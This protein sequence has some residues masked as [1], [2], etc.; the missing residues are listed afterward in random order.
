METRVDVHSLFRIVICFDA[1][2]VVSPHAHAHVHAA[3]DSGGGAHTGHA[4]TT[5]RTVARTTRSCSVAFTSETEI[6]KSV[7]GRGAL[8]L[9]LF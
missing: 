4:C 3:A 5:Q 8:L 7:S 2:I 9:L 6:K 1:F